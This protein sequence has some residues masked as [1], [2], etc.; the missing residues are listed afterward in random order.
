[1]DIAM[2]K[3]IYTPHARPC[4]YSNIIRLVSLNG[5]AKGSAE[6]PGVESPTW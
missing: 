6:N 4:S 2:E 5:E 1:M 3:G